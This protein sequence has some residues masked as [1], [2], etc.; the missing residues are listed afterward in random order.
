MANVKFGAYEFT[1]KASA[2]KEIQNRLNAYEIGDK[3]NEND[4]EFFLSLFT[5]HDEYSEKMGLPF[6]HL[7][8]V[9]GLKKSTRRIVIC[10]TDGNIVDISW[11]NCLTKTKDETHVKN[12]FRRAIVEQIMEFKIANLTEATICPVTGIQLNRDNCD[13]TYHPVSFQE[14]L[15][16]FIDE[17]NIQVTIKDIYDSE[18]S[19]IDSRGLLKDSSIVAAWQNHFEKKA[20]LRLTLRNW[21]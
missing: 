1:T 14:L 20:T 6:D 19:D 2:T 3:L 12:A 4:L 13:V 17:N 8:I 11:R 15:A 7:K 16:S 9:K 10:R 18:D 5:L 21:R